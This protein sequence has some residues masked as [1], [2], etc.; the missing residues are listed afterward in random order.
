MGELE[1][2]LFEGGELG[3]GKEELRCIEKFML[4]SSLF[5]CYLRNSY[6]LSVSQRKVFGPLVI[7]SVNYKEKKGLA[8]RQ[9]LNEASLFFKN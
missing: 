7:L 8:S 1:G 6:L 9:Q 2:V 5:C 4:N 3:F